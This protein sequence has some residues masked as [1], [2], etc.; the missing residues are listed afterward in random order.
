MDQTVTL[1]DQEWGQLVAII[2]NAT[3]YATF[4]KLVQQLQ[5]QS[6]PMVPGDGIDQEPP[7]R[8]VPRN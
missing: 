6:Q 5:A 1:S 3:G 7:V 8:R 4:N 2:A